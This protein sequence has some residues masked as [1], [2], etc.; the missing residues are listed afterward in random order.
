[1]HEGSEIRGSQKIA[2]GSPLTIFC[3]GPKFLGPPKTQRCGFFRKFSYADPPPPRSGDLW[4]L[5]ILFICKIT[6]ANTS[7][8]V[9]WD[10][11]FQV[12]DPSEANAIASVFLSEDREE[13]LVIGSVKSNL[14]HCE[15]TSAIASVAKVIIAMETGYIPPNLHYNEPNPDIPSLVEG[16]MKVSLQ[17]HC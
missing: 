1:M 4:C 6:F 16:K 15:P 7:H 2:Q 8:L 9:A 10:L 17:H 5:K 11:A 14:G 13:P 12:G 3:F